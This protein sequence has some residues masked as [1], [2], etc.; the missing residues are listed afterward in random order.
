MERN[1]QFP[2]S[3]K[4]GSV[5]TW[6]GR[7]KKTRR[8]WKKIKTLSASRKRGKKLCTHQ[9]S[10]LAHR[11][12]IYQQPSNACRGVQKL[13]TEFF[14]SKLKR[15]AIYICY[16]YNMRCFCLGWMNHETLQIKNECNAVLISCTCI[17]KPK[18]ALSISDAKIAR[19][20]H[21][22]T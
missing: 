12:V 4:K 19:Q 17:W 6:H 21:F 18:W 22:L 7:G 5:K 13:M 8:S 15:A 20:F 11:N 2:R 9:T 10:S 16:L 14:S 3:A 1:A